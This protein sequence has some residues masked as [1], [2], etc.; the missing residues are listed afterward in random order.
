[1]SYVPP[2]GNDVEI[3]FAGAYTPPAG[4]EVELEFWEE[5]VTYIIIW[6]NE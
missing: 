1:M 6:C 2:V 3:D 5:G 4:D